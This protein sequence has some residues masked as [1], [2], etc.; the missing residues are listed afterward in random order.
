MVYSGKVRKSAVAPDDRSP[1][2][3]DDRPSDNAMNVNAKAWLSLFVVTVIMGLLL[4]VPAGTIRYWQAWV[5]IG[6]YVTA[7]FLITLYLAK[8]D[9]ALLRRRMRGGPTAE[10]RKPQRAAMLLA[11]LAFIAAMAVPALDHRFGWSRVPIYAVILGECLTSLWLVAMFLV[12]RENTFSAATVQIAEG[13]RVIS[14]GPYAIV[15]HPLYA[16][17]MFSFIGTPLALGSWWGLLAVLL[18]LPALIWRLVDEE[19]LLRSS[20]PGYTEYAERVR[21]KLIPG[22][23]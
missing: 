22:V 3:C 17:G 23:F 5:Y 8:R 19:R 14:T 20:L 7:S 21:Y 2:V 1:K 16:V 11:S 4:F 12:L 13:Q 9:P 18:A 10:K 15:R 6:I